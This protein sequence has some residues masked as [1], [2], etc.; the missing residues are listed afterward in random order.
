MSCDLDLSSNFANSVLTNY[1]NKIYPVDPVA[2]SRKFDIR[3][4]YDDLPQNIS[5][6]LIKTKKMDFPIIMVDSSESDVSKRFSVAHQLGHYLYNTFVLKTD[7][8]YEKIDYRGL[9]SKFDNDKEEIF[10]NGFAEALLM[11]KNIILAKGNHLNLDQFLEL[12]S[13]FNVSLKSLEYR[14]NYLGIGH[15]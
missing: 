4:I 13:K 12:A 5:G 9:S 15:E 8:A 1:W 7:E 11:P 10:A 14:L 6:A 3:V 2:I